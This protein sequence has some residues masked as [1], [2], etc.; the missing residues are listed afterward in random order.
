MNRAPQPINPPEPLPAAAGER[1]RNPYLAFATRAGA[2]IAVVAFILWRVDAR[3]VFHALAR[4]RLGWFA[5]AIAVYLAGQALSTWRWRLLAKIAA[6]GGPFHEY[7]AYYFIGMFTNLFVPGLIGGD[8]ARALY[9]GRRQNRMGAAVASV[10]YDRGIGFAALFW[11][12]AAMA[13]TIR[14]VTLPLSL[15]RAVEVAGIVTFAGWLASPIMAR[16]GAAFGGRLGDFVEPILPYLRNPL[17]TIPAA[18]LS[19]ILQASIAFAQYLIA[20]G[21]GLNTPLTVFLLCVPI[22][23]VAASL[24]VTLNGLGVREAAYLVLFGYA[25][26]ARPEAIALGLLWFSA[27]TLAGLTGLIAFITTKLPTP[28]DE[29]FT[30]FEVSEGAAPI[31]HG[32]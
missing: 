11:F 12:A 23:N 6:L 3:P 31:R 15:S 24:P 18:I 8:A 32:G 13:P 26:I 5:M 7:L 4:E 16:V 25:G 10:I 22:A 28:A 19:I 29:T 9:L 1:R 17:A 14:A 30:P 21:L 27:T 20:R 2:G